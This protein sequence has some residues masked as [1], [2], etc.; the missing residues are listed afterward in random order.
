MKHSFQNKHGVE[1][2]F[3][4]EGITFYGA[5]QEVFYPYGSIDNISLSML[6]VLQVGHLS[7]ICSFAVDRADRAQVKELVR[8]AK[9]AMKTAPRADV[10]FVDLT[11]KAEKDV[12]SP[13]LPPEEQL[14]QYKAQF[15]QGIISKEEYDLKKRQLKG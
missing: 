9:A 10:Q 7:R 1:C 5:M 6:G 13:N 8:N 4:D 14:K 3:T 2:I 15:I 12:I 11:K